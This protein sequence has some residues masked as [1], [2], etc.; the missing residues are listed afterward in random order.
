MVEPFENRTFL[1]GFLN[2]MIQKV[3]QNH[4]KTGNFGPVFERHQ[5]KWCQKIAHY[6]NTGPVM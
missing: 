6:L 3:I 2:G 1:F 5:Q 4:L